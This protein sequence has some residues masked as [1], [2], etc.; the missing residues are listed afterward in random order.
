MLL[1]MVGVLVWAAGRPPRRE[2]S[3]LA[4]GIKASAGLVVPFLV[5]AGPARR[6]LAGAA[7]VAV[8]EQPPSRGSGRT[9]ST[10]SASCPTTRS[11]RRA[12]RSRTRRPQL[13]GAVLPGRPARLPRRGARG[14]RHRVRRGCPVAPGADLARRADPVR[15]AGWATRTKMIS[16]GLGVYEARGRLPARSSRP[17]RRPAHGPATGWRCRWSSTRRAHR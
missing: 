4:A 7:G 5:A 8:V 1:T 9:R 10:R 11:A 16:A 13:L 14:L 15:M 3:T 17:A 6:V 12:G 2:R